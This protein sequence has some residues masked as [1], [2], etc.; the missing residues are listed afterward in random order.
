M[1]SIS[2]K[3]SNFREVLYTSEYC[4]LVLMSLKP[5]EEIGLET[6]NG[7]DQFFRFEKGEGELIINETK[8]QIGDGD[9]VIVPKGASHNIINTSSE[10]DLKLY[11]IYSPAHH[12]DKTL[13][14]TKQDSET[15]E[16]PFDGKTSE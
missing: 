14:R 15:N 13:H 7:N 12:K 8:Y 6:H 3:N 9:V 1:E 2:L 16:A 4:Q 10:N 5:N 11:T